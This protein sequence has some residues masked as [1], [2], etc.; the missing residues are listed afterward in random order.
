MLIMKTYHLLGK[1]GHFDCSSIVFE[2]QSLASKPGAILYNCPRLS[3]LFIGSTSMAQLSPIAARL[4]R[5]RRTF[6]LMTQIYCRKKH[7]CADELCPE[8]AGLLAYALERI[9]KCP[10][11]EAKPTC[12]TCPVHCYKKDKRAEVRRMMA[13]SG[14]WM[15][16]YHPIL[17]VQHYWD[18]RKKKI[19]E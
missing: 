13:Y 3:I 15:V 5:E 16:L 19:G 14:P 8:C 11:Q 9:D 4:Q 2:E 18:E 12:R 17:T 6:Q 7:S 10:F 1:P